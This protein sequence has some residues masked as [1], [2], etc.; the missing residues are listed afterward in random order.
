MSPPTAAGHDTSPAYCVRVSARARHVRLVMTPDRGLEVVVPRRFD[1]RRI[2]ELVQSKREWIERAAARVSAEEQMRRRRLE[3]DP[4][5]LPER[6]HL[7]AVGEE[8]L[9][10]YRASRV[11][12]SSR[13]ARG[14]VAARERPG[15]RLVV[16]GDIDD[17][18]SCRQAIC[19][20]LHRKARRHFISRVAEV[21]FQHRLDYQRVSVRQQ[22]TRWASCSRRKTISLNVKL[23][24]L[25][26]ELVDYVILHELCH[27]VEMNHSPRFWRRLEMHDPEYRAHRALLK[28][29]GVVVPSWVD[30]GIVTPPA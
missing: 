30:H 27:T 22:R 20:W 25:R 6:I 16:T 1:R 4:P 11:P 28:G 17:A 23:L 19:R 15:R 24:L 5:C 10:E 8:W 14:R 21:A 9:V 7:A 2:P 3:A 18:D 29:A 26:P 13:N 12:D